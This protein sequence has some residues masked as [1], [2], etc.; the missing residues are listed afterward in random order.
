MAL[1]AEKMAKVA[2]LEAAPSEDFYHLDF[3][4]EVKRSKRNVLAM[5]SKIWFLMHF[6]KF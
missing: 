4:D 2:R 6:L 3:E 1:T 5:R